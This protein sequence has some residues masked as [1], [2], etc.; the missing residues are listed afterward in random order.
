MN[1]AWL[2]K[3]RRPNDGVHMSISVMDLKKKQKT[4]W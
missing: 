3:I 4:I 2:E 1:L